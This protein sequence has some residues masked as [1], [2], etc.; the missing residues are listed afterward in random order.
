VG[1]S[2]R[3]SEAFAEI[4]TM[5]NGQSTVLLRQ[6]RKLAS[7]AE[8]QT[9]D[10]ELLRSFTGQ[11]DESAFAALLERHGPMVL[12]VCR[13][14][15]HNGHD[16]EDA[17]Q[18]AFLI[19]ARKATALSW[20]ES[21]AGWLYGVAYRVALK[22]RESAA[23]R[24]AR[25]SRL[26]PRSAPDPLADI[27]L[28]ELHAVLDEELDRLPEKYRS[29]VV[30][31]CL[32]GAAR[33]E[34]AQQLG[35]SVQTVKNRLERG[36]ELLRSRLARRGLTLSAALGC[37]A[38]TGSGRAA[39]PASL[40]E[41]TARAAVAHTSPVVPVKVSALVEGVV[42]KTAPGKLSLAAVLLLTVGLAVAGADFLSQGKVDARPSAPPTPGTERAPVREAVKPEP[43]SALEETGDGVTLSSRV[44]G[45]DGKPFAG[46]EV[47]VW[48][49]MYFA[50]WWPWHNSAMHTVAPYFGATSAA[51]GRFHFTVRRAEF[52]NTLANTSSKP[53]GRAVVVAAAKGYGPAWIYAEELAKGNRTLQLV[54][55]DIPVKGRV[56]DLQARPVAGAA[57]RVLRL[58]RIPDNFDWLNQ[59]RWAGL[60]EQVTTDRDGRFTLTGIG[61]DRVAVLHVSGPTIE[62]RIVEVATRSMVD[63]KPATSASIEVVAGPTKVIEGTVRARDTGKPLAGA[64]VYGNEE[65][66]C[67]NLVVRPV[68]ALT[69]A[70][71]RYRLVGL[72]KAKSY[73]L[74]I[75]PAERAPYLAM[76][77]TVADT[78]GLKPV[79]AEF[80]LYRGVSVRIRL[81]DQETG[82]LVR[83][84]IHY[85]VAQNNALRSEAE[86]GAGVI[87]SREFMRVRATDHEGCV[88]FTAYPGHGAVFAIVG[89]TNPHYLLGRV[90]PED[91]K[92]GH[93]P[94]TKGD[95]GNGFLEIM[96][97]YCVLDPR[98]S[99]R[100]Q[101][102]DVP[103]TRGRDLEVR[104]L[105]PDDKP[106]RGA[107]AYGH[108]FDAGAS[109]PDALRGTPVRQETLKTDTLTALGLCPGEPRTL[110]FLH[111]E[112]KLVGH[113]VVNG[114]E[115]GPVTV[116]LQ[117]WG[118][119]TGRLVDAQGKPVA[120]IRVK[121]WH[122]MP[123]PGMWPSG[124]A[125][126]EV[127]TDKDGRFR[128]E[129]LDPALKRELQI[130][131]ATVSV[132]TV[133][134]GLTVPPGETK[135]LGDIRVEVASPKKTKKGA[136]K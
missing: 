112:R 69:D 80:S 102:F 67:N 136:T 23:R 15:L 64:W 105:G 107:T 4:L 14:I 40:A 61:R 17:C 21:V 91:E 77:R 19:L 90:R 131:G 35:W 57:V 29:P 42:G 109:R 123:R 20:N 1:L 66:Y 45:P 7:L 56:L 51:D 85:E 50:G 103:L 62:T 87:P 132:P 100:E 49:Y 65:A 128:L 63:G 93:Y 92:K 36:R 84:Q 135:N 78:E 46:A 126:G 114:T 60:S 129:Y 124:E 118:V 73:A 43:L 37:V 113:L 82:K 125:G 96:N 55:D 24:Q 48:W 75:Y 3:R 31:C 120:G 16:A 10:R 28:R 89:D 119:L 13:R 39:L 33:D 116:R 27:S 130:S 58:K 18:A 99:D 12:G 86:F 25:E 34:A 59:R 134:K 47:T 72:P 44:L 115:K 41:R 110:S 83:G 6:I 108:T 22:A 32:E 81:V 11:R 122:G 26:K 76:A 121:A 38:M 88:R 111:K 117:S 74:T 53:W 9:S 79:K 101:S 106:V 8:S 52:T 127:P 54:K 94:L 5:T 104:L 95:P 97:G 70:Q 30:L 2:N 133:L 71:G 68:K 98:P